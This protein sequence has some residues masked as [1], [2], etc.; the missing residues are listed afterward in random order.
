[1]M[2]SQSIQVPKKSGPQETLFLSSLVLPG[3][4]Y[5]L[6]TIEPGASVTI[7]NDLQWPDDQCAYVINC[8][9]G[10]YAQLHM[11]HKQTQP[12]A[13][14]IINYTFVLGA[15]AALTHTLV[16]TGAQQTIISVDLL[17]HKPYATAALFGAYALTGTQKMSIITTQQH[18]HAQTTSSLLYKGILLDAAYA[19]YNGIIT[20]AQEAPGSN[21]SQYNKNLILGAMARAQSIPSLQVLTNDVQCKHGSASGQ[22]DKQQ[23]QYLQSRGLK[24]QQAKKLLI[25]AFICDALYGMTD[26]SVKKEI[27]TQIVGQLSHTRDEE[28]EINS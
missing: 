21:A 24:E 20:I 28:H 23:L 10:D 7:Y 3:Q 14:A 2:L 12:L 5:I 17:L 1:M 4:T 18:L 27:I 19:A 15:S 25:Q 26:E 13:S 9:I 22:L 16:A 11:I 8:T 6:L